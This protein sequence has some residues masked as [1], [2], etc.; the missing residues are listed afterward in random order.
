MNFLEH[1]N[2]DFDDDLLLEILQLLNTLSWFNIY[3]L[4]I[5]N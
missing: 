1:I 5:A 2:D 4:S 3:N